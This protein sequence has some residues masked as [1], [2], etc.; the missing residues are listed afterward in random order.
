MNAIVY[1]A[2]CVMSIVCAVMLFK[3]Y[4]KNRFKLLFWSAL[5]FTGFA[6]NNLFLVI[7]I[8]F[9]PGYDFYVLRTL[10][11]LV[12]MVLLLYGLITDTV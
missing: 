10:P 6:F 7:D 4:A 3:G 12:G 5:G 8:T 1:L 9:F 2:C 11:A